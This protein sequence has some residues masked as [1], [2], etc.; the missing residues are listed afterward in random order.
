MLSRI[1][2]ER[3]VFPVSEIFQPAGRVEEG[4]DFVPFMGRQSSGMKEYVHKGTRS[5]ISTALHL[6]Q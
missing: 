2:V 6:C 1:I 3:P 5:Y 4:I